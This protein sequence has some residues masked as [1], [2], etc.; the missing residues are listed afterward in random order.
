MKRL[1]LVTPRIPNNLEKAGG[2]DIFI[3]LVEYLSRSFSI[4]LITRLVP[5][6]DINWIN[7]KIENK[8]FINK[9]RSSHPILQKIENIISWLKFYYL[10][11]QKIRKKEYDLIHFEWVDS[12]LFVKVPKFSFSILDTHDVK[13][14]LRKRKY[15]NSK[16]PIHHI[17]TKILKYLELKAVGSVS[18]VL[19]KSEYDR[20]HFLK[21]NSNQKIKILA[22]PLKNELV[23]NS[24]NINNAKKVILFV[25][26]L[27]RELNNDGIIR[28]YNEV[29]PL[30]NINKQ[31]VLKIVG[32]NP[33]AK[34]LEISNK[35]KR[36]VL[37]GYVED[38]TKVYEE[39]RV[40]IAPLWVG[41]GIIIKVL[42][43]LTY[44]LPT[45]CTSYGNQGIGAQDG[46]DLLIGDDPKLF[47][48]QISKLI[49]NIELSKGLS[50]SGRNFI[51]NNFNFDR[52]LRDIYSSININ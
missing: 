1:L 4:D 10:I 22:C 40:F 44:G 21:Y 46:V 24:W 25:G 38:L 2:D 26:D 30:L 14:L 52:D 18:L 28:F 19:A 48:T 41:G 27:S 42:D 29:W 5:E 47:A 50:S 49:S 8:L 7:S 35:D 20:N 37:T 45:V 11:N 9:Y 43:A 32:G 34:L 33:S 51:L 39:A 13:Y 31:Y 17:I 3:T 12:I 15:K 36:V 6:D 16:N 23:N